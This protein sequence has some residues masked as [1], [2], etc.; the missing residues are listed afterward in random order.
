VALNAAATREKFMGD[1]WFMARWAIAMVLAVAATAAPP[2][3]SVRK[4]V[5]VPAALRSAPFD[6]DR[7]LTVPPGFSVSVARPAGARFTAIASGGEIVVSR[8]EYGTVSVVATDGELTMWAS[9]LRAPHGGT[10][11]ALVHGNAVDT[12]LASPLIEQSRIAELLIPL[13]YPAHRPVRYSCDLSCLQP[14]ELLRHR[15]RYHV[16]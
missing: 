13:P 4:K 8:P 7:F 15:F 2:G 6:A 3:A 14:A 11:S 12:S 1:N 16:L 5:S 10:S 9:G